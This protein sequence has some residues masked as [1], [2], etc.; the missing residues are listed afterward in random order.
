MDFALSDE[1]LALR[2]TTRALLE[3]HAAPRACFTA[4][5]SASV[6]EL[7]R[8]LSDLGVSALGLDLPESGL[9]TSAVEQVLVAEELGRVVAPTPFVAQAAAT[10]LL[11]KSASP[12][13]A[14]LLESAMDAAIVV[15]AL[16]AVAP[17]PPVTAARAADGWTLNGVVPVVPG[18]AWAD[19]ILVAADADAVVAVPADA[20]GVTVERAPSLDPTLGAATV[21]FEN[22]AGTAVLEGAEAAEAVRAATR[23]AVLLTAAEATGVAERAL[24]MAADYARTRHQFGHPIGAF[25]AIKHR[26]ADML[27][28]VENARSACYGAAWAI[29]DGGSAGIPVEEAVAMAKAVASEAAAKVTADAL[30]IHGGIGCTFEH[31][32]HLFLRRAKACQLLYGD[33]AVHLERIAVRVLDKEDAEPEQVFGVGGSSEL[34]AFRAELVAWLD[35][36][37]PEGFGTPEFRMPKGAEAR[38]EFLRDLQ[39]RMAEGRWLAIHW[40]AEHG[41]RDATIEQ[42]I[43][44]HAELARRGVPRPLGHIGLNMCGPTIIRHG[45][46]EQQERFLRPMLE[47]REIWCEGFSE[48][49]AGSDLAGVRT[50]G[51]I[52]GDELV[53]DGQKTWTTGAHYAQWMFALVRT[54]PE[55][56]KHEGLS[57]VLVPMDAP[58]VTVRPIERIS[59]DADINEVFLDGVR[60]PLSNVVGPLHGGWKVARTTLSHERY[61]HFL[62]S[63]IGFRRTFDQIVA[64]AKR[65]DPLGRRPA[66]RPEI[67][68]ALAHKWITSHLIRIHGLRNIASVKAAGV[69]GPEG[70]IMKVYG[71]EEEKHLYEL[72]LSLHGAFGLLDR[73]SPLAP[74]RGKWVFGYLRTRAST[75]AGGTSEI[76]RNIIAERVLGMPRDPWAA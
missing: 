33:G 2:D 72:A 10:A 7:W 74:D 55:A 60:V 61:T 64:L 27:I 54:D 4:D 53:I 1:Q 8:R 6:R 31:D 20:P 3:K 67:R 57:F 34:E 25:Q 68:A 37:L 44:Y 9:T 23:L 47:G 76:Q 66:D 63:Q 42:Q 32:I 13:A 75:I 51:R 19:I 11:A 18:A 48:P 38:R 59:R 17:A 12:A 30:Q 24:R 73:G 69:P 36:N 16:P 50:R 70:A 15:A 21:R 5:D 43:V 22:C 71:Q 39:R 14:E 58:G 49:G 46:K 62:A 52:E 41:G 65:P 45:T 35:E 29:R 26:L 28:Q 56:P 40:P